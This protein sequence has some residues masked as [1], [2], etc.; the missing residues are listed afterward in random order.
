MSNQLPK[1]SETDSSD[2]LIQE[3]GFAMIEL[4]KYQTRSHP[5][6]VKERQVAK[7]RLIRRLKAALKRAEELPLTSFEKHGERKPVRAIDTMP[8][9]T[10]EEAENFER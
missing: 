2:G 1:P 8:E 5:D 10:T 4:A 3:L 7:G 9:L 6:W